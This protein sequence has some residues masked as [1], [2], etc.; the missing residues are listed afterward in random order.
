MLEKTKL[1]KVLP[2]VIK[3][4]SEKGKVFAQKAQ[5]NI[6]AAS[7]Q[8]A[9]DSKTVQ[10]T[11]TK[12]DSVAR[13]TTASSQNVG[14]MSGFKKPIANGSVGQQSVRK[15]GAANAATTSS[16][17]AVNTKSSG[18]ITKKPPTESRTPTTAK[19][20]TTP[21]NA[22]KTK[23]NHVPAKPSAFFTSLQSA[24][25][26]PGTSNAALQSAKLKDNKDG[27]DGKDGYVAIKL[28]C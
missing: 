22:P 24:S 25:K 2:R 4:G 5:D 6:S 11:E 15:T 7:K 12:G 26:K 8:K 9:L 1:D 27:K 20:T 16:A 19:P 14:E 23:I 13:A 21:T 17:V 28:T 10:L 3:R 18:S